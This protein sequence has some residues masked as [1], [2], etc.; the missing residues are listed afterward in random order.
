MCIRDSDS[1]ESSIEETQSADEEVD[2]STGW[3]IQAQ[4]GPT[5]FVWSQ[6]GNGLPVPFCRKPSGTPFG[7]T[8]YMCGTC[9]KFDALTGITKGAHIPCLMLAPAAVQAAWKRFAGDNIVHRNI[10]EE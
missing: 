9:D 3:F 10:P 8:P 5:H 6:P 2:L 4:G 7:R 1:S